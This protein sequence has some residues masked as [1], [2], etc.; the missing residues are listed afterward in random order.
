MKALFYCVLECGSLISLGILCLSNENLNNLPE[1]RVWFLRC[2]TGW[3]SVIRDRYFM[4]YK[5]NVLGFISL[6]HSVKL[7]PIIGFF[8]CNSLS[9]FLETCH[10]A[11][12]VGHVYFMALLL[13][14]KTRMY[15]G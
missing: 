8:S 1:I 7:K 4:S 2:Q 12:V 11:F 5:L 10:F 13:L 6:I 9:K 3:L 15:Y 14:S